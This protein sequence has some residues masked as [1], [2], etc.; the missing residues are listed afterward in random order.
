MVPNRRRLLSTSLV[1]IVALWPGSAEPGSSVSA[2]IATSQAQALQ[3]LLAVAIEQNI[4]SLPPAAGQS[5]LYEWDPFLDTYA[6]SIFL[7]PVSFRTPNTIGKG[8]F[9]L[10]G[11]ASFF[12]LNE[13]FRPVDYQFTSKVTGD[14]V[15]ERIGLQVGANVG[16]ISTSLTYGLTD[17]VDVTASMPVTIIDINARQAF[18][19]RPDLQSSY[20]AV[21]PGPEQIDRNLEDPSV[22]VTKHQTLSTMGAQFDEGTKVGLARSSLAG[23]IS[24]LQSDAVRIALVP[25]V[26][27]PS[28]SENQLSGTGTFAIV[29]RVVAAAPLGQR[30]FQGHLDLAYDYDF[31]IDQLRRF[32]WSVGASAAFTGWTIDGGVGGSKYNSGVH[33]SAER[34]STPALAPGTDGG[35]D[36]TAFSALGSTNVGD[37]FVD[38][39]AGVRVEV[40][41]AMTIAGAVTVPLNDE[42]VR[43]EATGTIAVELD[44]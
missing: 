21:G 25:E 30:R 33:W 43:P 3:Q 16:V 41:S 24:F 17:R 14:S 18:T 35:T 10:R 44:F 36:A 26:F 34:G 27:F 7:G 28:P 1:L 23:K 42:G 5:F 19:T 9:T 13:T 32:A 38:F 29:P 22:L 20:F 11:A 15:Y 40:T 12:A 37:T 4:S 8:R 6:R 39:L 2:A 31:D